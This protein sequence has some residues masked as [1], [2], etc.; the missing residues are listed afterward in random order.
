MVHID[1]EALEVARRAVE[2]TLIEFR[3]ARISVVAGNGLVVRE[4]DGLPS[5]VIRLSTRDG[6]RIGIRAYLTL[7]TGETP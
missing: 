3:D 1:E 4:Y 6:L 2:D 5:D 7:T